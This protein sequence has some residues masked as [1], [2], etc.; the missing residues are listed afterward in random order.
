MM[1]LGFASCAARPKSIA[2]TG[3]LR[4]L[5]LSSL[6]AMCKYH[7]RSRRYLPPT[8]RFLVPKH[9]AQCKFWSKEAEIQQVLLT[10]RIVA[11][12][13]SLKAGSPNKYLENINMILFAKQISFSLPLYFANV[14]IHCEK[15]M[16]GPQTLTITEFWQNTEHG[17][18]AYSEMGHSTEFPPKPLSRLFV[19]QS[20]N[21]CTTTHFRYHIWHVTYQLTVD[22]C[23]ECFCAF[24]AYRHQHQGAQDMEQLTARA[25][26]VDFKQ[27]DQIQLVLNGLEKPGIVVV[28]DAM[29]AEWT[30]SD[31]TG[32]N[33]VALPSQNLKANTNLG[34]SSKAFSGR[35]ETR[36]LQ[37]PTRRECRSISTG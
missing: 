7:Y 6:I 16:F 25:T 29:P 21:S 23:G 32:E 2:I 8:S 26:E 11:F 4:E 33:E 1:A 5:N 20:M 30:S 3:Q 17:R 37:L 24:R 14:C 36:N 27:R 31:Q 12:C 13:Q 19:E 35:L 28:T 9:L 34:S 15:V 22:L 18:K 10:R